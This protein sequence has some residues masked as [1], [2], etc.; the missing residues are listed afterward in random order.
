MRCMIVDLWPYTNKEGIVVKPDP[1]WVLSKEDRMEFRRRIGA[2][3]FPTNYSENLWKAFG[4]DD[5][6]NWPVYLNTHD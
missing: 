5:L 4:E 6:P 2:M 3:Q 1:T